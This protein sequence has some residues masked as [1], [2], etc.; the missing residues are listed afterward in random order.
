M[1]RLTVYAVNALLK[2]V[3]LVSSWLPTSTVRC[4]AVLFVSCLE[5]AKSC[6]MLIIWCFCF[7]NV[8]GN[9]FKCFFL[10][11]CGKCGLTYV[12]NKPEDK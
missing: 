9:G 6:L 3:V 7:L 11:Y 12:F 10:Q 8:C 4:L 1:E 5:N 2:T